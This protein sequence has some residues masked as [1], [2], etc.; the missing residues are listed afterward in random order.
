MRLEREQLHAERAG[1]AALFGGECAR[2][3]LVPRTAGPKE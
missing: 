3:H 1:T 2:S